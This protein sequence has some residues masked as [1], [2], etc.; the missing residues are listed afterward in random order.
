MGK[1]TKHLPVKLI[2]A[3]TYHSD[4]D[5][6]SVL[7]QIEKLNSPIEFR[8]E[9]YN[10]SRFTSYYQ[11]EMGEH[12]QKCFITFLRLI[13]PEILPEIKVQTNKMEED[14]ILNQKRQI[15]LDPGY[16]T[17]AKLVL[18]TTKNYSHRIHIGKGI[19]GDVH[20]HYRNNTYQP[21]TWTYPDY[22]DEKNIMFF[23]ATRKRYLEQLAD[24]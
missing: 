3:I 19:F 12:L 23:N 15:N 8:S 13:A 9:V 14:Y 11:M 2:T 22:K 24:I 7:S 18:A 1:I 20:L 16:I 10:F 4:F 21:Q 5:I 6:E 17:Q